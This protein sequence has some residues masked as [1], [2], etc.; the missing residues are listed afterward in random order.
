MTLHPMPIRVPIFPGETVDSFARRAAA[1]NHT[2]ITDIEAGLR[3]YGLLT[4]RARSSDQRASLWRQLGALPPHA[5]STPKTF[6][7]HPVPAR[8]LCRHCAE[9]DTVI[10]RMPHLGMI[11]LRHRCTLE[12][13]HSLV[14][15]LPAILHAERRFRHLHRTRGLVR[16]SPAMNIARDTAL[17]AYDPGRNPSSATGSP[18][19]MVYRPQVAIAAMIT[20]P[21]FLETVCRTTT[22]GLQRRDYIGTRLARATGVGVDHVGKA[23]QYMWNIIDNL[24]E[25]LRATQAGERTFTDSAHDLLP[26]HPGPASAE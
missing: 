14:D 21:L 4:S 18:A 2:T 10:A 5:F 20:D 25:Y 19:I 26:Y 8:T 1:A 7:S 22:P 11:C 6:N 17:L 16:D 12:T 13:P 24:T 15:H 3:H 23:L 9:G